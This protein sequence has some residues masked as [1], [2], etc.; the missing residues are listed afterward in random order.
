MKKF[1]ALFLALVL[2]LGMVACGGNK[3]PTSGDGNTLTIGIQPSAYVLDYEDN[4]LTNWLEEQCGVEL[5]FME[6]A[7]GTDVDTQI[8]TTIAAG[9]RLPD[10]LLGINLSDALRLRYGRDQYFVDMKNYF[11][12][13][14]GA[15]KVF[16]DR[17]E[18][19]L[20]E[21]DQKNIVNYMTDPG[22]GS[23]YAVPIIE[24]S[25]FDA[26]NYQVY[27]N[28]QWMDKLNLQVPTN[29]EELLTVLRA[30]KNNDCNENGIEDEIPLFGVTAAN[31]GGGIIDWL[32]N[33]FVYYDREAQYIVDENGKIEP[34]Y[35]TDEYREALK[36]IAQMYKE[37][38]ISPLTFTS[39]ITEM[40][41][42]VTPANGTPIVGM[43]VGHPTAH[44]T[45]GS[46]LFDLYEPIELWCPAVMRATSCTLN[47]FITADCENPDK[48]FELLMTMWTEEG[49]YRIRYGEKG[50]NWDD[51][52]EGAKSVVGMDARYKLIDDSA[53]TS[54]NSCLWGGVKCTLNAY[55]E[56]ESA[57]MAQELDSWVAGRMQKMAKTLELYK[58]AA[59]KYNPEVVCPKLYKTTAELEETEMERINV[60]NRASKDRTDFITGIKDINSDSVWK[61]Y[62]DALYSM[63]LQK[64]ID[65]DQIVYDRQSK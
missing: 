62:K 29:K 35:I 50:V 14:E 5:K 36:F 33:M 16:W 13:K 60:P 12:D 10:I 40:R 47:T 41:T 11:A 27:I 21:S 38:L 32:I 19:E 23:I 52:T 8:A 2:A 20:S 64:I 43:F 7:G 63:G 54:Q 44:I 26:M 39:S 31:I 15:S 9:E 28:T 30:F 55:A 49:S 58:K 3:K 51:P 65:Q 25:L 45:Q 34:V 48:A 1:L 42:I 4:A 17:M 6:Y 24:T 22:N 59:E 46:E 18:Y 56:T 57:E 37:G 53:F 61:E